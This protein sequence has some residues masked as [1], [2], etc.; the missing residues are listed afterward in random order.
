MPDKKPKNK[1]PLGQ[2][3]DLT[4][5]ELE[6]LAQVGPADIQQAE[7]LWNEES[8]LKGLL[9]ATPDEGKGTDDDGSDEPTE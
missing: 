3:L 8:G 2:P 6:R 5:D 1:K 9:E 7:L 4:D